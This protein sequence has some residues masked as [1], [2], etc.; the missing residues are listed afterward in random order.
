MCERRCLYNPEEDVRSSG[1]WV[2]CG[3]KLPDVSMGTQLGSS[4]RAVCVHN[5]WAISSFP[6]NY[7]GS[8]SRCVYV[9]VRERQREHTKNKTMDVMTW[10]I[11]KRNHVWCMKYSLVDYQVTSFL[12]CFGGAKDWTKRGPVHARQAL[13][14][15][16]TTLGSFLFLFWDKV[17]LSI[18][19][20]VG[21]WNLP[22]PV[23]PRRLQAFVI[24]IVLNNTW[25]WLP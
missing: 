4:A 25:L 13:Y 1:A 14:C 24:T 17:S 8:N 6:R 23:S 7:L 3:Y 15:W 9:C 5:C 16:D 11:F 2:T 20:R 18:P 22:A 12:F 21:T 19:C 10:F